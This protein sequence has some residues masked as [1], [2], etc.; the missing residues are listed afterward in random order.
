MS[1]LK[2]KWD[3]DPTPFEPIK[4]KDLTCRTCKFATEEVIN[5]E[6]FTVKPTSVLK[7]GVCNEYKKQ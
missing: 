2:N 4:N 6:K 7:G 5:C 1:T 3:N